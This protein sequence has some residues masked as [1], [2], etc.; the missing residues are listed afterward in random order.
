MPTISIPPPNQPLTRENKITEPWY[1][2]LVEVQRLRM[3]L[4]ALSR[5]TQGMGVMDVAITSATSFV[6]ST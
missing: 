6:G 2:V 1:P 3:D 5:F 4:D